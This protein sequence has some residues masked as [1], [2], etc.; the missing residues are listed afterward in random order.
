M[1]PLEQ[2]VF[3]AALALVD[4]RRAAMTVFL[5]D[6]GVVIVDD[7]ARGIAARYNAAGEALER[8][9]DEHRRNS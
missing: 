7:E 3:D 5:P 1:T 2:A 4:A 9:V 6:H 8:A